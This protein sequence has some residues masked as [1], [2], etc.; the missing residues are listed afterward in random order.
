[1]L[2]LFL[3]IIFIDYI[4]LSST[5]KH[6]SNQIQ[7]IQNDKLKLKMLPAILCYICIYFSL[8]LFIIDQNKSPEM[9]FLLGF[10][11]YGIFEFTNQAIFKKWQIKSVIIDTIW[12]GILYFLV[13]K[14]YYL[15]NKKNN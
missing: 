11:T 13:I 1:M 8:K 12:G 14:F 15:L 10:L 7:I 9:A 5:S 3:L 4:Y 2:K 6:F